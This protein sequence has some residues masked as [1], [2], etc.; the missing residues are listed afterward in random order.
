MYH[1]GAAVPQMY[2]EPSHAYEHK[3]RACTYHARFGTVHAT[4]L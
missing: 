3:W 2:A 1:A 4:E